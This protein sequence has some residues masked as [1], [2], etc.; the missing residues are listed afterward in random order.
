V[1]NHIFLKRIFKKIV[2]GWPTQRMRLGW[3]QLVVIRKR[4]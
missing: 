2:L 4:A 3:T 1:E